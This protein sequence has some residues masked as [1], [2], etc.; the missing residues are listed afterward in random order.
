MRTLYAPTEDFIKRE[1][2]ALSADDT[3]GSS[4]AISVQSSN[5]VAANDYVVIGYEGSELAELCQVSETTN[6]TITVSTLKFNHKKGEPFV[7]Y[8]FNKRKFYG[9]TSATAC[10][11]SSEPDMSYERHARLTKPVIAWRDI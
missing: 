9:A 7:V 5:G 11:D 2:G 10:C 3:A 8:R 1:R 6:T 4:V